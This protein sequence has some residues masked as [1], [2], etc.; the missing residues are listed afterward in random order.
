MTLLV[1]LDNSQLLPLG[2]IIKEYWSVDNIKKAQNTSIAQWELDEPP[3]K[4][5][6]L[7]ESDIFNNE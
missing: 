6:N 5:A 4:E 1:V 2:L 7:K 3:S